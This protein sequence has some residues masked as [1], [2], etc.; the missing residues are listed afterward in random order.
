[1]EHNT[2]PTDQTETSS[3]DD[4]Q[5]TV[6]KPVT[7]T[8]PANDEV[9]P[10]ATSAPAKLQN[11]YALTV[12]AVAI[13]LLLG[14][15]IVAASL[16]ILLI[17]LGQWDE[18][19]SKAIWTV[20]SAAIFI[21]I[22]LGV[23]SVTANSLSERMIRSTNALLNISLVLIVLGFLTSVFGIWDVLSSEIT[24]KLY[25]TYLVLLGTAI[26]GKVLYDLEGELPDSQKVIWAN[27]ATVG[28]VSF[29]LLGLIYSPEPSDLLGGFYGR[30]LA[31]GSIATA[32]LSIIVAIQQHL[33]YQKHPEKKFQV[34]H[35]S[36][37]VRTIVIT[38][39]IILLVIFLL[40]F[41]VSLVFA[42]LWY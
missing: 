42:R 20:V 40:P 18:T 19:T 29:L 14:C 13:K 34:A 27:Y 28:L 31:A 39:V 11:P 4:V 3:H 25:G 41:I 36:G 30:L 37:I 21:M 5:T 33:Y 26:Y 38:I 2:N 8:P 9:Q 7:V 10:E 32:T 1:M 17:L 6:T 15:V 24:G 16:A 12:R 23:V 35:H 22:A